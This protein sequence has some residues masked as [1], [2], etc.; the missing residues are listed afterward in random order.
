[1]RKMTKKE[2]RLVLEYGRVDAD[3][4]GAARKVLRRARK[5]AGMSRR[6]F[7]AALQAHDEEAVGF[8]QA[9]AS[10]N[11]KWTGAGS[12]ATR[13]SGD[14]AGDARRRGSRPGLARFSTG[15]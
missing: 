6:N 1:M 15:L 13:R 14:Y 4:R 7:A 5:L 2:R 11:D 9:A 12:G 3:R 10:A 8:V